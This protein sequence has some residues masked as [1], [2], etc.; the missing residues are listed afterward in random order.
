MPKAVPQEAI[1]LLPRLAEEEARA[2]RGG[3]AY[4][5]WGSGPG[6]L[7]WAGGGVPGEDSARPAEQAW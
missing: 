6:H 5:S 1:V 4:Q 7:S 2:Q 3:P